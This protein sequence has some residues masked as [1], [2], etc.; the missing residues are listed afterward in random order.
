MATAREDGFRL[1]INLLGEAVLGEA[2]AARRTESTRKLLARD[3][4]DYVSIKISC[5]V[6]QISTWDTEGT[7]ER[8]LER[9]KTRFPHVLV[10]RHEPAVGFALTVTRQAAQPPLAEP[11]P[12][13]SVFRADA[14]PC[15]GRCRSASPTASGTGSAPST[16]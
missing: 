1:N 12:D 5:L 4:V 13:M 8:A 3:D 2:E 15:S 14:A 11:S 16:C 6:S 10:F 7:V 9:L